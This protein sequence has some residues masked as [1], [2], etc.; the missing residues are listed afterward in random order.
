MTA[1][2]Y[3]QARHIRVGDTLGSRTGNRAR[4]TET[5]YNAYGER[6]IKAITLLPIELAGTV[7]NYAVPGRRKLPTAAVAEE[8]A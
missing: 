1:I 2:T 7:V 8:I 4:V 3:V 5:G 6:T